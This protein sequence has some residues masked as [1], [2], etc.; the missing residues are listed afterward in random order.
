MNKIPRPV[1][2]DVSAILE[3]S[4]NE[5]VK[6]HPVLKSSVS[7]IQANYRQYVL[8]EGNAFLVS[9]VKVSDV[10]GGYLKGHYAAP[11]R[12]LSYIKDMRN[13]SKYLGCPMCGSM[14]SGT[15]DHILPKNTYP[16]FAVFSQN[17][18][19]AC[20]CNTVRSE[21]LIG[22]CNER[23]LHPYFDECLSERL[24]EANLED[25]GP[26]PRIS[27]RLLVDPVH[28]NYSAIAFHVREVVLK[29]GILGYLSIRW[30]TFVRK[31]S[32]VVRSLE[33]DPGT[34]TELRAAL[35]KERE[36]IDDARNG[37]NTW[38]SVF[39]SG[40]LNPTVCLWIY[41]SMQRPGRVANGPLT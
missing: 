34:E 4:N 30:G 29:T 32:L 39:I 16:E 10:A 38:D 6:S 5:R 23:I 41:Q 31:P 3:L 19:Q 37:K 20:L 35:I 36:L 12:N 25:L 40:L 24:I 7:R 8:A 14:L 21:T 18:V 11:P 28:S 13:K 2:D 15:L 17:L 27:L 33:Q 22:A 9:P 1:Y 26:V